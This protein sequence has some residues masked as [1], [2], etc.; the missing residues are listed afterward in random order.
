[1]ICV[2]L[3]IKSKLSFLFGCL[4]C[5]FYHLIAL[6]LLCIKIFWQNKQEKKERK[7]KKVLKIL[8]IEWKQKLVTEIFLL[9]LLKKTLHFIN[10]HNSF[11]KWHLD[12]HEVQ[13]KIGHDWIPLWNVCFSSWENLFSIR[14]LS[15][16][17]SNC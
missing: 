12:D 15:N 4:Y 2:N 3:L 9:L 13:L 17:A 1:M 6:M 8:I 10:E 11:S 16:K 5:A 7:R 14:V